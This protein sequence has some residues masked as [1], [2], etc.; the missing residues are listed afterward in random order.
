MDEISKTQ[1]TPNDFILQGKESFAILFNIFNR[2][3]KSQEIQEKQL[4]ILNN[5]LQEQKDEADEG[6]YR[7]EDGTATTTLTK[8]DIEQLLGHYVKGYTIIN[9]GLNDIY[10]SHNQPNTSLDVSPK[11]KPDE[12]TTFTYNRNKI[13]IIYLNTLSGTSDYRLTLV[14]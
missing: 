11:V 12:K 10:I 13:K 8:I 14:W 2:T 6:E 7:K 9:D 1:K 4:K 3:K 5:I